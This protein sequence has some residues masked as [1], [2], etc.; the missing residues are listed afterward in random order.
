MLFDSFSFL[1]FFPTVVIVYYLL[2]QKLQAFWLLVVSCL[3]YMAF[4]P[5]YVLILFALITLDFF[6]AQGIA[7]RTGH[8]RR[9]FLWTS[10]AANIGMLF[11]FKY[12]NFFEVNVAHLAQFLHWNYSP[13]LLALA[14]PLGLSFHV[15]Q[16]LSY[17]IEVYRGKYP[18]EKNYLLYALYVM[19]FPQLVAGPIERPAHL[20]PQFK[21]PHPFVESGV[22][23]GLE[24]MLWGFFKKLVIADNLALIVDHVYASGT[25][26]GP[27]L[28]LT[29]VLFAYQLY[30]D[31][32][33]YSDIAV[34]AARVLGYEITENFNRPYAA[35][36]VSEFWRRWH[37]SL[38]SW[39]RDYLYY[40]LALSGKHHSATRLYA[41]LF[42]TFVL[43]GLWHGANW[44]FA[45]MG[46]LFGVYLVSGS[47]TESWRKRMA[48]RLGLTK[49]PRLYG[50]WQTAITFALVSLAWIF[51]R[52]ESITQAVSII[53]HLGS[54]LTHVFSITYLRYTLFGFGVLGGLTKLKLT[55]IVLAIICME[56]VQYF[57]EKN[58]TLTPWAHWTN[59]GR[60][61]WRYVTLS[62]IT[63]LGYL[64]GQTF[65][66]F[67]F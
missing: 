56:V 22:I 51:F 17:V 47:I 20:L 21:Q 41:S 3:F 44:T 9:V 14:L 11:F 38:S 66:Y 46:A 60:F 65:I 10:V 37:I 7:S 40:P 33:G 1:I 27:I 53:S 45:A 8:A 2:P 50:L 48:E 43:I 59:L 54:G 19:F 42:I 16:S 23:L 49:F 39:L 61:A 18:P 34:G 62:A 6:L 5:S 30:C 26:E 4:V 36:S 63:I 12:F 28:I 31:F 67:R 57:Q 32:S 64:G 15:F 13:A 52:S 58:R 25:T 55:T 35:R 24:R 29:A